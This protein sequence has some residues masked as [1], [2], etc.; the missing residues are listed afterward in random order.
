MFDN[1]FNKNKGSQDDSSTSD[2]N[3][4]FDTEEFD[5]RID[6]ESEGDYDECL[7]QFIDGEDEVEEEDHVT[8]TSPPPRMRKKG[9]TEDREIQITFLKYC[10]QLDTQQKK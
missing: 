7:L 9:R 6:T 2:T 10:H 5:L 1:F 4:S 8:I 3:M